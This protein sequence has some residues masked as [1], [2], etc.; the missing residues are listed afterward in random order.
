MSPKEF[1]D[2]QV[3][4]LL[5]MESLNALAGEYTVVSERTVVA[6]EL[7]RAIISMSRLGIRRA[8]RAVY[9]CPHTPQDIHGPPYWNSSDKGEAAQA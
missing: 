4:D 7:R 8:R 5:G 1:P 3:L 2:D 9:G 6:G